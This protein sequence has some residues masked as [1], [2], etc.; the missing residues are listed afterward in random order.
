MVFL[1]EIIR[2]SI[3]YKF[4]EP[5]QKINNNTKVQKRKKLYIR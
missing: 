2:F 5:S 1:V 4:Q 3:H